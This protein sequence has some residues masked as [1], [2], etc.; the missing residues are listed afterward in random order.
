MP[1]YEEDSKQTFYGYN[2]L[3]SNLHSMYI[4]IAAYLPTAVD[5]TLDGQ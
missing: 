2:V 4:Y 1:S 3:L 5:L